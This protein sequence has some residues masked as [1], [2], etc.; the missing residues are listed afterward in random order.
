MRV[1]NFEKGELKTVHQLRRHLSQMHT[2]NYIPFYI[3]KGGLLKKNL[4]Q[5]GA[6]HPLN[7]PLMR[8]AVSPIRCCG[9]R[10]IA[11]CVRS[12]RLGSSSASAAGARKPMKRLRG[13]RPSG[14][15]SP[16]SGQLIGAFA[17]KDIAPLRDVGR[18]V[19]GWPYE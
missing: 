3:R 19:G 13:S 9:F 7:P 5:W 18:S 17:R 11:A 6:P 15:F 12:A 8:A 4:N 2:S 14:P 10:C 1:M 16:H